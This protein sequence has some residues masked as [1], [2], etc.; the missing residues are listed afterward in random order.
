MHTVPPEGSSNSMIF[1]YSK[2]M[3]L[4]R[5]CRLG[6]QLEPIA[7]TREQ[8][9]Q[10]YNLKEYEAKCQRHLKELKIKIKKNPERILV[11]SEVLR[12]NYEVSRLAYSRVM[13]RNEEEAL[14][15]HLINSARPSELK[16]FGVSKPTM[17]RMKKKLKNGSDFY[18]IGKGGGGKVKF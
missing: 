15:L 5:C 10:F 7:V 13:C 18:F 1:K 2:D 16:Y 14:E 8:K 3:E 6:K 17:N 4:F 9:T 11:S 12:S